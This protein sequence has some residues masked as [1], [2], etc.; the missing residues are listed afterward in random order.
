MMLP[1]YSIPAGGHGPHFPPV[2][3]PGLSLSGYPDLATLGSRGRGL[4][5]GPSPGALGFLGHRADQGS[6]LALCG[7]TELIN[8]PQET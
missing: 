6:F 3:A 2:I 8:D 7:G 4:P 5:D 1:I